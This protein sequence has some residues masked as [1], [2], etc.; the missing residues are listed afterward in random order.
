MPDGSYHTALMVGPNGQEVG[1]RAKIHITSGEGAHGFIHCPKDYPVFD[2]PYGKAGMAICFDRYYTNVLHNLA[3]NGA[4]IV[5]IPVDDDFDTRWFH[6]FHAADSIFRAAENRL[7]M[8]LST[9]CSISQVIDP[10]DRMTARSNLYTRGAIT[11]LTF[12]IDE[13]PV[14]TRL[15]DWFSILISVLFGIVV[16][17]GIVSGG[18]TTSFHIYGGR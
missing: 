13:Q 18:Q 4:R 15:G 6:A 1:R 3:K 8:G 7:A 10:Y 14:Y 9:T 17:W 12:T 2:T 11:G 5:L 16:I